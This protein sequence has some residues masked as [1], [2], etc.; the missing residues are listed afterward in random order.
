MKKILSIALV[1]VLVLTTLVSCRG[2]GYEVKFTGDNT[3]HFAVNSRDFIKDLNSKLKDE[4]LKLIG[5]EQRS[6]TEEIFI[7]YYYGTDEDRTIF[8]VQ[9]YSTKAGK[10]NTEAKNWV[11]T[12]QLNVDES[13]DA[14]QE[15]E[16]IY[17]RAMISLFCSDENDIQ[18]VLDVL[19]EGKKGI[20]KNFAYF[21]KNVGKNKT[22]YSVEPEKSYKLYQ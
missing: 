18:E 3:A 17:L 8:E 19:L 10:A 11:R 16:Q 2:S 13:A 6:Y 9:S 22:Y 14:N 20:S 5:A 21:R 7:A 15:K 4:K 12:I 1:V